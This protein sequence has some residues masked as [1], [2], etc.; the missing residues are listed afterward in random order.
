MLIRWRQEFGLDTQVG[1]LT[2]HVDVGQSIM[3]CG[4]MM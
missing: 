3:P 4:M 2:A 1:F